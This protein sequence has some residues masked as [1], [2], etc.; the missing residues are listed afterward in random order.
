MRYSVHRRSGM[1]IAAAI[2]A[3][4]LPGPLAQAPKPP[5]PRLQQATR[6]LAERKIDE[7]L[8]VLHALGSDP[9]AGQDDRLKAFWKLL[10]VYHQKKDVE[11]A[12]ATTKEMIA[13][14]PRDDDLLQQIYFTQANLLGS[15]RKWDQAVEACHQVVAHAGN[16]REKA[17]V[18]RFRAATFLRESKNFA[19]LYDEATELLRLLGGDP[20]AADAL[21]Q[22]TDATWQTG[23]YE[24]S[25]EKARRILA[26]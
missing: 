19:Q 14:F 1:L 17:V 11:A 6:A 7:G 21:W 20:R 10:E 24:E 25:L 18:A 12:V 26:E 15:V 5:D 16:D 4:V 22:L 8:K 2:A 13:A 9:K 3:A 23:R